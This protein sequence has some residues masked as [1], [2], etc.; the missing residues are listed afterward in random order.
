[1]VHS[2]GP[3]AVPCTYGRP[4]Q[5]PNVNSA[6][7]NNVTFYDEIVALDDKLRSIYGTAIMTEWPEFGGSHQTSDAAMVHVTLMV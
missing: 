4:V 1:M 7:K 5:R 2:L 6:T 3:T